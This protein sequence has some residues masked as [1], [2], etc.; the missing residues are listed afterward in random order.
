M[1][2]S[3]IPHYY[4]GIRFDSQLELKFA[5]LIEHNFVYAA[6]PKEFFQKDLETGKI[7]LTPEIH[8]YKPDFYI[9][10]L[11]DNI[12]SYIEIKPSPRFEK[13]KELRLSIMTENLAQSDTDFKWIFEDQI[14]LPNDQYEKLKMLI[15]NQSL[16]RKFYNLAN[17]FYRNLYKYP[18]NLI[19]GW[20]FQE[21]K[22]FLHEGTYP[23]RE[24]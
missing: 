7:I 6:H 10:S 23:F 11:K 4:N 3:S 24:E 22:S 12:A 18:F 14:V 21:Y 20:S 1:N 9:R 8:S 2:Y 16:E 5:L 15:A 19:K 17:K 13:S